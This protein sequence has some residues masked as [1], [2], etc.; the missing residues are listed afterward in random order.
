[1]LVDF[2]ACYAWLHSNIA[3]SSSCALVSCRTTA[4][5][6]SI[7]Q[8][9]MLC[10]TASAK[11]FLTDTVS[12]S[13]CAVLDRLALLTI[14]CWNHATCATFT[15]ASSCCMAF[16]AHFCCHELNAQGMT[17]ILAL[18]TPVN[19]CRTCRGCKKTTADLLLSC[20]VSSNCLHRSAVYILHAVVHAMH[21]VHCPCLTACFLLL[22]HAAKPQAR[23]VMVNKRLH[24]LCCITLVQHALG[25]FMV[26]PAAALL[27]QQINNSA[28]GSTAVICCHALKANRS[29]DT[30][31]MDQCKCMQMCD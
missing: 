23:N 29:M 30:R 4:H 7:E 5:L 8:P 26:V 2:D 1:M 13:V 15:A 14:Y 27:W 16:F 22:N 24:K 28:V 11:C 3:C 19:L 18:H 9:P 6:Y 20:P 17:S 25:L 21:A 12:I 31:S 10:S